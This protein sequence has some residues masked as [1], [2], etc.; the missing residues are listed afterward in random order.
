MKLSLMNLQSEKK[1]AS[2]LFFIQSYA[3]LFGS[4]MIPI[5][6]ESRF[7][8]ILSLETENTSWEKSYIEETGDD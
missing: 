6:Q 3:H 5:F 7:L 2:N 8:Y 1:A 4:A